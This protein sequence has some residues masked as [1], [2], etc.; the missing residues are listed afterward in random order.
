M[1]VH[2]AF[3]RLRGPRHRRGVLLTV[4]KLIADLRFPSAARLP[5]WMGSMFRGGFGQALRT[6]LCSASSSECEGCGQRGDC[7]FYH[8]YVRQDATRGYAPPSRPVILIPPFYGKPLAFEGGILRVELLMFGKFL[9]FLPHV[10]L[11]MQLL[12]QRGLGSLRH[13]RLNMFKIESARCAFSD[14]LVV[15]GDV[16]YPANIRAIDVKDVP[17]FQGKILKVGFKTPFT[18][19]IFPT[20]PELME[21]ARQNKGMSGILRALLKIREGR[22]AVLLP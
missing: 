18:G 9:Q 20:T 12:G 8:M 15:Q 22:A 1:G 14:K 11:G 6:F 16:I 5:Y 21:N 7:L 10:L 4:S 19:P 3:I 17:P 2:Q 13:Y